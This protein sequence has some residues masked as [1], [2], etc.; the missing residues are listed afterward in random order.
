MKKVN[1]L[2]VLALFLI[3]ISCDSSDD[4]KAN[5]NNPN[6]NFIE[7]LGVEV[8]RDFMGQI[9]DVNNNPLQHVTIQIDNKSV[10]TDENGFFIIKDARVFENLAYVKATKI[11]YIEGSR[12]LV[13]TNEMNQIRIM[14]IPISPIAT[15]Q[16]GQLSEVSLPNQTKVIFDGYFEDELG[17][18]YTGSVNV[19]LFHLE[20]S[21]ENLMDIMPGMLFAEATDGSAKIL[22]T[23][24][25]LHVELLGESG[26]KL[27]IASGHTAQISM[28]I[29]NVHMGNA[30]A[31]IPLWHFDSEQGYW[32]QEGVATRQ[33]DFYV[34][35]VSHFSWWNCDQFGDA[36]ILHLTINDN[37]GNPLSYS[38]V[39]ILREDI[40][41][42]SMSQ[43]SDVNG[44]VSGFVPANENLKAIIT[45]QCENQVYL[46]IGNLQ[47]NSI[48]NIELTYVAS[49][50]ASTVMVQGNLNKCDGSVVS[51]GYVKLSYGNSHKRFVETD[52]N[53]NF[54][55]NSMYCFPDLSFTL[56]GYNY[57]NLQTTGL[58]SYMYLPS[59]TIVQVG[60]LQAC[61]AIS[62]FISYQIDDEPTVYILSDI[63]AEITSNGL[64]IYS[65][66]TTINNGILLW[67]GS[68]TTG[69][70]S[71]FM[72]EGSDLGL[73]DQSATN[74]VF[75]IN[76]LGNIGEFIDVS[77]SGSYIDYNNQNRTIT[78]VAHVVRD[79]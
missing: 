17:N 36:T 70:Q 15:I 46:P 76:S 16:A 5:N 31:S 25:M 42:F 77:F 79:N 64:N 37:F 47:A 74:I 30:P 49:G 55:I 40:G 24:G 68:N 29:D 27:Q 6:S 32:K 21:N 14:M 1:F 71:S 11:G 2:F 56:Q 18:S 4:S 59:N 69:V 13:P 34:G 28:K 62:E 50:N 66:N 23:F 72:I 22:E 39:S 10:Q 60:N 54:S 53:G 45:D 51:N 57:D 8:L 20:A 38:Q 35:N 75:T 41:V 7:N 3:M 67:C 9:V 43:L 12:S 63:T 61:N 58:I 78:G 73:I 19:S 52:I 44:K 26:Q 48:N 65:L 33:G